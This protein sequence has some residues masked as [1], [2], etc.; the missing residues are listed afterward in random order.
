M[1][2][3]EVMVKKALGHKVT[4]INDDEFNVESTSGNTYNVVL[5]VNP[6]CTCDYGRFNVPCICSHVIAVINYV[7]NNEYK[8]TYRQGKVYN[9]SHLH[10]KMYLSKEGVITLRK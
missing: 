10:R 5:D 7:H 3:F 4:R 8:I 2:N 6:T 9:Y 1:R